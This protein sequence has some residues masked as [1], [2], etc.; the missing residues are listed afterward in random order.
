MEERQHLLREIFSRTEKE[1]EWRFCRAQIVRVW[2]PTFS[3]PTFPAAN[4]F[5]RPPTFQQLPCYCL[6]LWDANHWQD[7]DI[8]CR[9]RYFHGLRIF[10]VGADIFMDL[11]YFLG[12]NISWAPTFHGRRHFMG[13]DISW[14]QTF[15]GRGHF[16]VSRHFM[17]ADISWARTFWCKL[18]FCV[19]KA[20]ANI[21]TF[22]DF[23]SQFCKFYFAIS[24]AWFLLLIYVY[25]SIY[26]CMLCVPIFLAQMFW[27]SRFKIDVVI[28]II[29]SILIIIN[30]VLTLQVST[31]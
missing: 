29:C 23:C 25:F 26:L 6:I 5:C 27:K 7:A 18:I 15:H 13:A 11:E 2:T 8:L 17:G 14:A 1:T 9:R 20:G 16:D 31:A 24:F 21:L 22:Y 28:M 19:L 10:Y 12:A 4:I 3:A 30:S